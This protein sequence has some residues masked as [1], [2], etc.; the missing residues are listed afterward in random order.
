ML[1]NLTAADPEAQTRIAAFMQG[2]Q[3]LGWVPGRNLRVDFRWGGDAQGYRQG[4][5]ELAAT[6][7]DLILASTRSCIGG[8][9]TS[10]LHGADRVRE[11]D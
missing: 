9:P 11:H 6:S 8:R 10:Y 7:P 1:M 2:L 3:E 4:A 5:E